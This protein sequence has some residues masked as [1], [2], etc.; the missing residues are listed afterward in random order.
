MA[1][2]KDIIE[3]L[4]PKPLTLKDAEQ[5]FEKEFIRMALLDND[6]NV[7]KTAKNIGIR[8]ETLHRK[9]KQLGLI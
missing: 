9:A 4:P 7:T 6:L 2:K 8:Y 5:E 3:Q 1:T